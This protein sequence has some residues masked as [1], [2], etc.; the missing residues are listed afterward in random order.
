MFTFL[1]ADHR[2]AAADKA[3]KV[4][5]PRWVCLSLGSAS[6]SSFEWHTSARQRA[7][8]NAKQL[9]KALAQE[10]AKIPGAHVVNVTLAQRDGK[11]SVWAV[12]RMPRPISPD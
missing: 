11:I 3:K 1:F 12:A 9:T 10:I 7:V 4:I 5:V 2:P 8:H 6:R